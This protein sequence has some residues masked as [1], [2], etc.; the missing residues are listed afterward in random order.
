M[1]R[2]SR[3]WVLVALVGALSVAQALT[4]LP[5]DRDR[6]A[7]ALNSVHVWALKHPGSGLEADRGLLDR[8]LAPSLVA[9][10]EQA[11]AAEADYVKATA[12][13][14]KQEFLEG[15]L[16]VGS[17]E[18]ATEVMFGEPRI[19]GTHAQVEVTAIHIDERFPKASRNR[20]VVWTNVVEFELAD[21]AWRMSDVLYRGD[22]KQ[23]LS[24]TLRD[25]AEGR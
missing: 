2:G 6:I 20:V 23:R 11:K 18:G 5:P 10:F 13:G 3:M 16:I 4:P 15:D 7:N 22:S 9:A 24:T 12:P 19:D 1:K 8:F 14:E 25:Y 17:V 21:N